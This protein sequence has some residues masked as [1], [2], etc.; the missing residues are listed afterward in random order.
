[1][2]GVGAAPVAA[3]II[4]TDGS[5]TATIDP[6]SRDGMK[7]WVVDGVEHLQQQWFW[8]RS[9]AMTSEESIDTL[10]LDISGTIVRRRGCCIAGQGGPVA[11]V[12][13]EGPQSCS[14]SMAW[15]SQPVRCLQKTP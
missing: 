4:L 7:S 5:S 15:C 8:Y 2:A 12:G 6:D 3:D 14:F 10:T 9:V 13:S 11:P 1:M